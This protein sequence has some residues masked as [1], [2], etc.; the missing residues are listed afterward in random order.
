MLAMDIIQFRKLQHEECDRAYGIIC[1][2]VDWLLS[3]NI[4]QWTVPLPRH[5]YEDRQHKEQ[6]FTL[7][8]DG[9]L[10]VVLS[11]GKE[12]DPHW[13]EYLGLEE[14]WWLS[15]MATASSFRGRQMGRRAIQEAAI[16][17]QN[18]GVEEL[19]LDCVHGN[20]FLPKYYESLGFTIITRKN[21]E[22]PRGTFD[23]VLMR[24]NLSLYDRL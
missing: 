15:T 7:T 19:Y 23:M 14:H 10:A 20:G 6:N 12:A 22:Y 9:E 18:K 5:I 4:R 1:G 11:L 13:K 21:I 16:F 17:L 8:C 3:K 24:R 2:T